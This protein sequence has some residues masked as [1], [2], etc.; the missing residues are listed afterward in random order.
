MGLRA[1][2]T[3]KVSGA[4]NTVRLTSAIVLA[5]RSI[6]VSTIW[7]FILDFAF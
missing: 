2:T 7:V 4:V 6:A 3:S 1:Q 5:V